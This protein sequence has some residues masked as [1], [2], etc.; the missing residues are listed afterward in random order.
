MVVA[1]CVA[2][3]LASPR[4]FEIIIISANKEIK[5]WLKTINA[6]VA[7]IRPD[8]YLYGIANDYSSTKKL[9]HSLR[10]KLKYK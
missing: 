1:G 2:I 6:Y 10:F 8:R 9:L 3:D 7:L 5:S 4:L